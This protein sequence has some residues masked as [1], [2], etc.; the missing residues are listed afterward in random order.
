MGKQLLISNTTE[1]MIELAKFIFVGIML[2]WLLWF[3]VEDAIKEI[4]N[5]IIA[6]IILSLVLG[7]AYFV[8]NKFKEI[9][10]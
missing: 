8:K 4:P 9:S 10:K 7:F 1:Q 3:V 6:G 5:S 2:I